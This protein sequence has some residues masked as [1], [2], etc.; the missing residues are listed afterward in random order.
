M[1]K[2]YLLAI[3][4]LVGCD[5]PIKN[6][7]RQAIIDKYNTTEIA[8]IPKITDDYIVRDTNGVVWYVDVRIKGH[9]YYIYTSTLLFSSQR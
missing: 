7:A 5:G 2:L 4:L 8:D 6:T 3:L 9:T 1:K